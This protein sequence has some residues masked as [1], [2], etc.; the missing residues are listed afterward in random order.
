[1]DHLC[2][3]ELAA[4]KIMRNYGMSMCMGPKN[5]SC[6]AVHLMQSRSD[7]TFCTPVP[8]Y[9]GIQHVIQFQNHAAE[10]KDL[11]WVELA[12]DAY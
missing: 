9:K 7:L 4:S 1:M 10:T 5:D 11:F 12:S 6:L 3:Q 2:A 8:V